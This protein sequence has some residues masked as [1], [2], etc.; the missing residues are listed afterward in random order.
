[1]LTINS[2]SCNLSFVNL[3]IE[4]PRFGFHREP[5]DEARVRFAEALA[6]A[7]TRAD[8]ATE[9]IR[10]LN[11]IDGEAPMEEFIAEDRALSDLSRLEG[12]RSKGQVPVLVEVFAF[13]QRVPVLSR[14]FGRPAGPRR[15]TSIPR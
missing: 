12:F 11:A 6:D 1:M 7:R 8:E 15:P 10:W 9:Q 13:G 2:Q 4:N 14:E 5:I 3:T